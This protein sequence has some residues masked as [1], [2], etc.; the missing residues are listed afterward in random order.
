MGDNEPSD[1]YLY[2]V[3]VQTGPLLRCTQPMYRCNNLYLSHGTNSKV[4]FIL[5]GEDETTKVT[6]YVRY[7][8]PVS[9][10]YAHSHIQVRT[11]SGR[12]HWTLS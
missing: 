12:V 3:L 4:Q 9:C 7:L 8:Q 2:E 11:S 6:L 1:V 10:R 5:T